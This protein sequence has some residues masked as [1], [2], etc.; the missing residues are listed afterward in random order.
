MKDFFILEGAYLVLGFFVLFIAIFVTTRPF[1]SKSAPKIGITTTALFIAIMIGAHYYI[2]SS[3]MSRVKDAF[4][5]GDEILCENRIYTKG[6]QFITV[7]ISKKWTLE[8]FY[9]KSPNYTRVFHI[10]RCI[11]K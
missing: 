6:A 3:R 7:E 5:R 2:T 11:V 10:S 9:F 1:M 8:G 4:L